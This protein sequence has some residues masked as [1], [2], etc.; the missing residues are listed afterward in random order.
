MRRG[1]HIVRATSQGR[2]FFCIVELDSHLNPAGGRELN[3]AG[4]E[5]AFLSAIHFGIDYALEKTGRRGAGWEVVVVH[6]QTM[7]VDSSLEAVAAAKAGAVLDAFGEEIPPFV[8]R[9]GVH[10]PKRIA[11]LRPADGEM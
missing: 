5:D 4:V 11:A 1:K 3:S 9:G 2:G 7:S 6:F 10:L 8:D